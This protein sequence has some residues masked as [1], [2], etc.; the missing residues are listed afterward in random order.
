MVRELCQF[1]RHSV[2]YI[3]TVRKRG[4]EDGGVEWWGECGRGGREHGVVGGV[5]EGRTGAWSGGES[6]GGERHEG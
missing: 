2:G 6:V 5:W 3:D 4:G 1:V